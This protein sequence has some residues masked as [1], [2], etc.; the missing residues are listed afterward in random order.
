MLFSRF[1][2][3]LVFSTKVIRKFEYPWFIINIMAISSGI[4]PTRV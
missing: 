1:L 3:W 4:E 2:L